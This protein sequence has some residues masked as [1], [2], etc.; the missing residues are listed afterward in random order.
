M[1]VEALLF[2]GVA[3]FFA[4]SAA[5]Y[6]W[7]SGDPAGTAALIV[8]FLMAAVVSFFCAVHY[9]RHGQRPQD[10]RDADVADASGPVEFFPPKSPWPIITALGFAITATGVIYGLWLFLIGFGV[11]AR[12]V[13]GMVFQY[14]RRQD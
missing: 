12:G 14:A 6:G 7:W 8:A 10:R 3:A 13:V 11:L 2:G 1:K 9:R 5:L 4:F